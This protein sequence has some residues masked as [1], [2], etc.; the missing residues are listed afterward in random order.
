MCTLSLPKSLVTAL[1]TAQVTQIVKH[2]T[3]FC[4]NVVLV[5]EHPLRWYFRD[6]RWQ[7]RSG[8]L[9]WFPRLG[10]L[11]AHTSGLTKW[12]GWE[13]FSAHLMLTICT[14]NA[15]ST[16]AHF[17][18]TVCTLHIR[19]HLTSSRI[20]AHHKT[21]DMHQVCICTHGADI[22]ADFM[23]TQGCRL[24]KCA[25]WLQMHTL[26]RH[27]MQTFCTP[28]M[29]F[30]SSVHQVCKCT[31]FADF[32]HIMC[33]LFASHWV[34]SM[35]VLSR[36]CFGAMEMPYTSAY[37]RFLDKLPR[38]PLWLEVHALFVHT[39]WGVNAHHVHTFFGAYT[40][41]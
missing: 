3:S 11:A 32:L 5:R 27:Y 7:I 40:L 37:T 30:W 26:C 36:H 10:S 39:F 12:V 28:K 35:L 25:G 8:G 21:N 20:F 1:A 4:C 9:P 31:L 22:H 29:I 15:D 17:V 19:T 13:F 2:S 18:Q 6:V 41:F 23:H 16:N 33:R 14:H 24:K 34:F 38:Q